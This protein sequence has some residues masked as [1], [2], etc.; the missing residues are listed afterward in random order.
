MAVDSFLHDK[1]GISAITNEM[2]N[3]LNE[4]KNHITALEQL[5]NNM[6]SSTAWQDKIVKTTFII[7][8]TS[9][10]KAYKSLSNG[11]EAYINCLNKK[12]E[13]LSEHESLYS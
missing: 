6:N 5:I 11:I 12:S 7:T 2:T 9:Y 13:N 10:I 3:Y 1:D 8:S 4:Y